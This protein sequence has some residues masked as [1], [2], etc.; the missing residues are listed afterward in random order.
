VDIEASPEEVRRMIREIGIGFLFAPKM[1]QAMR[2]VMPV[3]R[4]M[5][6]RTVFNILGPLTNPARVRKQVIGVFDTRLCDL[7][8][9]VLMEMGHEEAFIVHGEEGMDE[10]SVSGPTRVLHLKGGRVEESRVHP[11]DFGVAPRE[12]ESIRGGTAAEN[13]RMIRNVLEGEKGARRDA[14]CMNAAFAIRLCG[15]GNDLADAFRLAGE[16]LDSGKAN[17]LLERWTRCR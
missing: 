15:I 16:T 3:R 5:G 2:F 9:E 11:S 1:H 12:L 4:N 17:E 13:A 10:I 14:A 8:A 6:I 7:Y